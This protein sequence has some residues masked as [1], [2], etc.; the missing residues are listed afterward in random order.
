MAAGVALALPALMPQ[1]TDELFGAFS[2][3]LLLQYVRADGDID[4]DAELGKGVIRYYREGRSANGA[5]PRTRGPPD[6]R[7]DARAERRLGRRLTRGAFEVSCRVG[8]P[9]VSPPRSSA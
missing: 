1:R 7:H 2:N 8:R 5:H 9:S 4:V 3:N 6:E